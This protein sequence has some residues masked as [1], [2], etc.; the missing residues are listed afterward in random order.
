M[1]MMMKSKTRKT[2]LMLMVLTLSA[3]ILSGCASSPATSEVQSD[4]AKRIVSLSP[5]DMEIL[6]AIGAGDSVVGKSDYCDY[7]SDVAKVDSVGECLMP[8]TEKIV[9]LKPDLLIAEQ[10]LTDQDTLDG[11]AKLGIKVLSTTPPQSVPGIYD[12]IAVLGDVT[13]KTTEAEKLIAELKEFVS[14]NEK[15]NVGKTPKSIYYVIDTG[16]YGE[17]AATG[18]TFINDIIVAAGG[19]NIA[20]DAT[21]WMFSPEL[22]IAADPDF[23]IGSA[24]NI[25]KI[26]GNSAYSSLKALKEDHLVVVDENIFSRPSPRAIEEGIVI[27]KDILK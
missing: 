27:L 4:S 14:D 3:L 24:L 8:S 23:I 11:I 18:D 25:S 12:K 6:Y 22:L 10:G 13:G 20:K 7:P 19:D 5:A 15:S 21:G 1:Q 2:L 16:E 17:F 26:K 9:A